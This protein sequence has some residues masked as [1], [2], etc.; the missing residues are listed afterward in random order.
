MAKTRTSQFK[1]YYKAVDYLESLAASQH[2]QAYMYNRNYNPQQYVD[3]TRELIKLL[4]NPHRGFK[5]IHISGTSGKGST[6]ALLHNMLYKTCYKVGSFTS[7]Y[8]T[9]SIEK[10]KVDDKL[11]DPLV[12]AKLVDDMKPAIE[13][14]DKNYKYGRPSYF[15]IF[16]A[17]SMLY[18][19]KMKCDYV[20]MEVG[21]GGTYDAGMIVP[22]A[23]IAT[24]NIGLDHQH[25]LGNTLAKIAKEKAGIIRKNSHFFTT[26]KRPNL[27]K[28][29]KDVC[30]RQNTKYHHIKSKGFDESNKKLASAIAHHLK[31]DDNTIND[32][33]THTTLPCRFEIIQKNPLIILDGAH[34]PDKIRNVVHNLK[35]LTYDTLYTM[36]ASGTTKDASKMLKQLAKVSDKLILTTIKGKGRNFHTASELNKFAKSFKDKSL[37]QNPK[38]A[39]QRALKKLKKNDALLITG[40]FYLTGELRKNWITENNILKNRAH[41]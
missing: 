30:K 39:L 19:K 23:I 34:N 4:G 13:K 40:S 5:Y 12:F 29:F 17:I 31:I 20:I 35:N 38:K 14:M 9:T 26:E 18:F 41:V 24:T 33:I 36:F 25:L 21:C 16:F 37:E 15:E 28:L 8:A 2:D 32:A 3:R 22:K 27:L 11:I 1:P 7:P 10:I 6:V